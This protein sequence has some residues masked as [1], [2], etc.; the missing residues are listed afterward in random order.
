ALLGEPHLEVVRR[1]R[2]D[3]AVEPALHRG[4]GVARHQ[5]GDVG[6]DGVVARRVHA[7]PP[8]RV[9]AE[10]PGTPGVVGLDAGADV[11]VPAVGRL[12]DP[13]AVADDGG[14]VE[15]VREGAD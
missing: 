4:G 14:D 10:A 8:H 3:V 5:R 12:D 2:L 9:A 13:G 15:V 6:A 1:G 11:G 7:G